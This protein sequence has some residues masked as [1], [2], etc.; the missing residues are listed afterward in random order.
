GQSS[1][2]AYRQFSEEEKQA[3]IKFFEQ[4]VNYYID[5]E[6]RLFVHAGFTNQRGPEN[7][8]TPTPF[9]WDRTLW[10]MAMS[11][12]PKLKPGDTNYPKR[13][14]LFKMIFIGHTP[15]TRIGK[16]KPVNFANV[17]NVD[18]GAAFM[19]KL[20]LLD[21]DSLE[22]IQSDPVHELYPEE[23]GRN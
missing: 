14:E 1:I 13:L 10:E 18:T 5:K 4:M 20:S 11:L 15:V 12:D 17:Y 23:S 3:H 9:Y 2:D 21:V 19:G 16:D 6:N 22:I 7:E 8:Y